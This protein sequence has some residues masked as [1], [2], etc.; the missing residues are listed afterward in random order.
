MNHQL[1]QQNSEHQTELT[2]Q[3][4]KVKNFKVEYNS[5][6]RVLKPKGNSGMIKS[7]V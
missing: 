5:F 2:I 3:K 6:W 4:Q 7:T 1:E